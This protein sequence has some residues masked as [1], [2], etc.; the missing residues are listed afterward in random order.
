MAFVIIAN[1][2]IHVNREASLRIQALSLAFHE[3]IRPRS[4]ERSG[5]QVHPRK[6]A[7]AHEVDAFGFAVDS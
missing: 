3:A 2:G 4:G 1:T 6:L 5:I 7:E